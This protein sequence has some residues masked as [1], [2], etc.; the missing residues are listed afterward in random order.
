EGVTGFA[1]A[2]RRPVNR[3]QPSLDLERVGVKA[4]V[5]YRSMAALPLFKDDL[6]L[7]ALSLYSTTLR[8]YTNN[9]VRLL[10]TV[11]RLASGALA[12]AMHHAQTASKALTDSLTGFPNARALHLRFE[13]EVSRSRRNNKPF[14]VVMLDLDDFKRV[15]DTFGHKIG[16]RMLGD[17]ANLI[18][19]Q[20]REYDFLARYAGDEFVALLPDLTVQQVDELRNRIETV[21]RG[22][23]LSVRGQTRASVGIS[24]G[25][26]VFGP[27]GETLDQL[28]IAAD[29][30]MY[31]AKSAHKTAG[32]TPLPPERLIET[33]TTS[34]SEIVP[35]GFITSAI[36]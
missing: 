23:A 10:E 8:E 28:L 17:V 22:F 4:D 3:L 30:A 15:N 13:E 16:D 11:T 24:I 2:N 21:V 27:D 19:S 6:L 31:R 36:H 9:H 35:D 26:S 34:P 32:L 18:Q 25:A 12:N 1:L 14:Q 33:S 5:T 7:G 29:Q 20:L